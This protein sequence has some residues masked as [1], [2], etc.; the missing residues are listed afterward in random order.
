[1]QSTP[2]KI[3]IYLIS[4]QHKCPHVVIA[5]EWRIMHGILIQYQVFDDWEDVDTYDIMH[6]EPSDIED[7]ELAKRM[8]LFGK[9]IFAN[10]FSTEHRPKA[11]DDTT[12]AQ[13]TDY[14]VLINWPEWE[15]IQMQ[16]RLVFMHKRSGFVTLNIDIGTIFE[17]E[18]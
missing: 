1:M 15:R 8:Y 17:E 3:D 14:N 12:L 2:Q 7:E 13:Q 11:P 4:M 5:G 6:I 9:A 18:F 10:H 16:G